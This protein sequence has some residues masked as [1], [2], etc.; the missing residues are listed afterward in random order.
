MCMK[1]RTSAFVV[2][3]LGLWGLSVFSACH[4]ETS[5]GNPSGTGG[6]DGGDEGSTTG[7]GGCSDD[8]GGNCGST[9]GA[10]GGCGDDGGG[11]CGTTTGTGGGAGGGVD[12]GCTKCAQ[13]YGA[14]FIGMTPDPCPGTSTTLFDALQSCTCSGD[15]K[16]DC[17]DNVCMQQMSSV[18]CQTCVQAADN[19]SP[20]GCSSEIAA[21]VN[22]SL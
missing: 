9:T 5:N 22:A 2:A 19:A 21:C 7:A 14:L 3:A 18:A 20:P 13:A 4:S 15:C 12:G 10:G 8:G 6:A 11:D 1:M 16:S 17:A